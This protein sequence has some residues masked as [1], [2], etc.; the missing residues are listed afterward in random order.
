LAE[1]LRRRGES[2]LSVCRFGQC[3][4]GADVAGQASAGGGFGTVGLFF[5]VSA[6]K[7]ALA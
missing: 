5:L 7:I 6:A 3:A 2:S 4:P 1:W